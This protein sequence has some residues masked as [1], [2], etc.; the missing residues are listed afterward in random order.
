M[1]YQCVHIFVLSDLTPVFIWDFGKI[2][3]GRMLIQD[4]PADVL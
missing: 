2:L 1:G 3:P 4:P